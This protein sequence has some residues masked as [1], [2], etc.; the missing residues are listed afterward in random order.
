MRLLTGAEQKKFLLEMEIADAKGAVGGNEVA[1]EEDNVAPAL[2]L[3]EA[4]KSED[5]I[6]ERP[7]KRRKLQRVMT[8]EMVDQRA[9]LRVR[10]S[11]P[12]KMRSTDV[13]A[14]SKMKARRPRIE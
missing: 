6:E 14:R 11:V 13:R 10:R 12:T 3:A 5:K 9:G 4:D 7:K 2:P 1:C 8:S